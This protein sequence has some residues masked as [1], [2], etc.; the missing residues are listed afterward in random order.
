MSAHKWDRDA[1]ISILNNLSNGKLDVD[2]ECAITL[3]SYAM[4]VGREEFI[5][6]VND[7]L[8]A[9][10]L[11]RDDQYVRT[12]NQGICSIVLVHIGAVGLSSPEMSILYCAYPSW[13][14]WSNSFM[15][16]VTDPLTD[17]NHSDAYCQAM[18]NRT[19]WVGPYGQRRFELLDF[20]I[21]WC[22]HLC[23]EL[24]E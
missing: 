15:F 19:M 11:I 3:R 7:I 14:N 22:T 2:C 1:I 5:R 13:E 12:D 9:L 16:P 6:R 20:L 21:H 23:V 10:I 4:K 17:S 8:N 24:G 18:K